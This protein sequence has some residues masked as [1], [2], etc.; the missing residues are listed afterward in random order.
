MFGLLPLCFHVCGIAGGEQRVF[1]E[2]N[3]GRSVGGE[4]REGV[5]KDEISDSFDSIG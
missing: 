1:L 2:A 3:C 5:E 4:Q